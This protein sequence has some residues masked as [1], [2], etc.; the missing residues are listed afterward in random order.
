MSKDKSRDLPICVCG[1]QVIILR[2]QPE[3][4]PHHLVVRIGADTEKEAL[5]LL[6]KHV[7]DSKEWIRCVE[8]EDELAQEQARHKLFNEH[9]TSLSGYT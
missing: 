3:G 5:E 2:I 1:H 6:E 9:G 8:L 7:K 4:N